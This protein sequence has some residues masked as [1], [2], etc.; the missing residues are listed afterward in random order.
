MACRA[1]PLSARED[2]TVNLGAVVS[3]TPPK[4]LADRTQ[5]LCTPDGQSRNGVLRLWSHNWR[6]L[7]RLRVKVSQSSRWKRTNR[8]SIIGVHELG[9][10]V[11]WS[12]TWED[13]DQHVH[14]LRDHNMLPA[15]MPKARI[16][17]G[18]ELVHSA[19]PSRHGAHDRPVVFIGHSLS[20]MEFPEQALRDALREGSCLEK[21]TILGPL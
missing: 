16:L 17:C 9:S 14:W 18:G 12:W 15:K 7:A 13:G 5:N 2:S 11:D 20:E 19:H 10:N 4:M 8:G 1:A 3:P 21:I 6:T